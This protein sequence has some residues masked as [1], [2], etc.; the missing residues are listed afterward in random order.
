MGHESY[1]ELAAAYW[2]PGSPAIRCLSALSARQRTPAAKQDSP[3][4]VRQAWQ[5]FLAAS[6][7]AALGLEGSGHHALSLLDPSLCGGHRCGSFADSSMN[8]PRYFSFSSCGTGTCAQM[9]LNQQHAWRIHADATPLYPTLEQSRA[10]PRRV[11]LVRPPADAFVSALRRFWLPRVDANARH[12]P[13]L[14][15]PSRPPH[16]MLVKELEMLVLAT[17]ELACHVA[18]LP[19]DSTLFLGYELLTRYPKEHVGPL[20]ALLQVRESDPRLAHFLLGDTAHAA[21]STGIGVAREPTAPRT[22]PL[23]TRSAL[24]IGSIAR[25][26]ARSPL[27]DPTRGRASALWRANRSLLVAPVRCGSSSLG[28][29]L[30]ETALLGASELDRA[31]GAAGDVLRKWRPTCTSADVCLRSLHEHVADYFARLRVARPELAPVIPRAPL[32]V[33]TNW[34]ATTNPERSSRAAA[35]KRHSHRRH[36]LAQLSH[37]AH[38]AAAV[39]AALSCV[40]FALWFFTARGDI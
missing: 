12:R 18:A 3:P 20:A 35:G 15:R 1:A 4:Q 5:S 25:A 28:K 8:T 23:A 39:F 7:V 6:A 37:G 24:L 26:S 21:N 38:V 40:C 11:V 14:I 17:L 30:H 19:C 32:S 33:C 2:E 9:Q 34:S 13:G 36:A 29:A 16:A 10:A 31:P 27:L 22:A